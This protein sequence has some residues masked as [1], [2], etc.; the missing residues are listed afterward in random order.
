ME[1]FSKGFICLSTSGN[2]TQVEILLNSSENFDLCI[3]TNID[4]G[5]GGGGGGWVSYCL[6][7]VV[8]IEL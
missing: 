7:K 5:E 4:W 3:V 1:N 2:Y 8:S 6:K